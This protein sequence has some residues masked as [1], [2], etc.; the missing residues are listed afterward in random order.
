MSTQ[1]IADVI[2][3]GLGAYGSATAYQLA[4]RG[5][6]VIGIDQ[7]APPHDRGSSHGATR[8]TRLAVGEGDA[9]VPVVKRSH[10]I[11]GELEAELPGWLLYQRTGGIVM[12]SG[13]GRPNPDGSP[14]FVQST[15]D[16]AERFSIPHEIL[17][18][19]DISDRFP[20]FL[21]RG[22]ELGYYEPT[23]GVLKPEQ[24]IAAQ[25]KAA[26]SHGADIRINEKVLSI[27][28][29]QSGTRVCT[30]LGSYLARKVILSAGAWMPGLVGSAFA[31]QL[32]V[33][34]QVLY[35]FRAAEP[36]LFAA[37]GAPVFLWMHG[38]GATDYMYGFPMVDGLGGVKVATAQYQTTTDPDR[39]NRSVSE[40][41]T[42][43][44]FDTHVSGR[45]RS[46]GPECIHS[47]TCFY[48]LNPDHLRFLVDKHPDLENVTVVSACS[49]HGF[50]HSAAMGEALALQALGQ[51]GHFELSPFLLDPPTAVA[52]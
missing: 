3:I 30:N 39:V 27:E 48:T 28:S 10:E 38:P 14:T 25:I 37:P 36:K 6:K 13:D 31:P 4:R 11:W 7:F 5:A 52:T 45:L 12:G 49:G 24:C 21:L 8:I 18:G 51:A 19:R 46:V 35:W 40:E 29:S 15:K 26:V 20:Q 23:A 32:K 22:D 34:R 41:E 44:M 1:A 33:L 50:K 2:V 42:R 16:V 17:H 9:Y 47:A 43:R